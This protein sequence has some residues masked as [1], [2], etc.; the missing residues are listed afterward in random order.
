MSAN[1]WHL[2]IPVMDRLIDGISQTFVSGTTP[3]VVQIDGRAG[4]IDVAEP[5]SDSTSQKSEG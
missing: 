1:L 2:M 3:N 5:V 4:S